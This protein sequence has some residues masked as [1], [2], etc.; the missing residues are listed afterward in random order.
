MDKLQGVIPALPTPL[1][2]N[3]DVDP[4]SLR[5]LIDYAIGCGVHGIFLM[6]T[7]GEGA[8]LV[9]AQKKV[10]VQTAAEHLN[11]KLPLVVSIGEGSTRRTLETGKMLQ[12]LGADY[13]VSVMP[14]YYKYPHPDSAV[15]FFS[16]LASNL[17]K[18]ILFYD[19]PGFTG[20]PVSVD[21]LERI[22]QI[23]NV[24]GVK[25]SSGNFHLVAEL[26]RRYPDKKTRP[27]TLLQG[28]EG[29][30]DISLLMGADGVV[31]G[32][33]SAH[34]ETLVALYNA[35]QEGDTMQ[36][37]ALQQQFTRELMDMMGPE[38]PIDW[39][40]AIKSKLKEKGLCENHVTSPFMRRSR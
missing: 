17:A 33:G 30:Y 20:N 32:G 9:D 8:C 34:I 12:D 21:T 29:I 28:D 14:Y 25:D 1:R 37:F 40:Y 13:F 26:L 6:G 35:A 10:A 39:M 36:A 15:E 27:F 16:Q 2:E 19:A 24:H 31:T 3:E 22:M 5:K 7:M 23:P 11:G 38:L 18:P 4:D